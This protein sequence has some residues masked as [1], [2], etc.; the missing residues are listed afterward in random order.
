MSSIS[1]IRIEWLYMNT[2]TIRPNYRNTKLKNGKKAKLWFALCSIFFAFFPTLPNWLN[3]E[4]SA[5]SKEY[6]NAIKGQIQEAVFWAR[7][8]TSWALGGSSFLARNKLLQAIPLYVVPSWE[9]ALFRPW[10]ALTNRRVD[11]VSAHLVSKTLA[12][13]PILS[14]YLLVRWNSPC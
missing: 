2:V 8:E 3:M 14:L 12:S 4:H 11:L 10:I 7:L 1:S 6:R 13:V 9:R 5:W